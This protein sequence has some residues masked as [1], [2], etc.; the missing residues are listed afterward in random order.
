MSAK[1]SKVWALLENFPLP[2]ELEANQLCCDLWRAFLVRYSDSK[3]YYFPLHLFLSIWLCIRVWS[4]FTIDDGVELDFVSSI[5]VCRQVQSL[6]HKGVS[7]F[8]ARSITKNGYTGYF[9]EVHFSLKAVFMQNYQLEIE[10]E[11]DCAKKPYNFHIVTDSLAK[12][13]SKPTTQPSL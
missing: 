4:I 8:H 12:V 1:G 3:N 11:K 2:M 9:M 5:T 7:L 13:A 10:V 6:V